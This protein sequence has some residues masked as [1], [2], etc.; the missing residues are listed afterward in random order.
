MRHVVELLETIGDSR[1]RVKEVMDRRAWAVKWVLPE[2]KGILR[3]LA[4]DKKDDLTEE[5]GDAALRLA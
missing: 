3:A 1:I 5:V 4:K 2:V